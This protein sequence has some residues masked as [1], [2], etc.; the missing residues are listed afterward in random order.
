MELR[1]DVWEQN[2]FMWAPDFRRYVDEQIRHYS[3]EA[4]ED[5]VTFPVLQ[6]D[7]S[8]EDRNGQEA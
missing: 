8:G 1:C 7:S 6:W 3:E 4:I 2:V 5:A